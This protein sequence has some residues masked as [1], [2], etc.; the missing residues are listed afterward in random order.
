LSVFI[1]IIIFS[2]VVIVHELGHF[3]AARKCGVFVEEFAIGMG[4]KLLSRKAKSGTVY[5]LRVFP[6]GGFCRMSGDVDSKKTEADDSGAFSGKSVT[7]RIIIIVAGVVLNV[8]LAFF[9]SVIIVGFNGYREPV[10][11]EIM[12]DSPAESIGLLSGDRITKIDGKRINIYSEISWYLYGMAG[13]EISVEIKRGSEKITFENVRPLEISEDGASRAVIGI[14]KAY[15]KRGLFESDLKGWERASVAGT[16]NEAFHQ[17][18]FYVRVTF[19]GLTRLVTNKLTLDDLSGPI[20]IVNII[21]DDYTESIES[22]EKMR[23]EG[24][25]DVP[26]NYWIIVQITLTYIVL[27]SANLGVMNLLPLPA[28]DGGRLIFLIIEGIRR[29]PIS[30]EREGMVHFVGFVLLML[31]AAFIAFNDVLRIIR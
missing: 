30:P 23:N 17:T 2:V 14:E 28:L 3:F 16:V 12:P 5:S 7:K 11:Y 22:A 9:V 26:P 4:P 31:F 8:F 21:S 10:I 1:A 15:I 24:N 20:G 6:I 13:K 29:K 18:G 19:V 27:L 25:E